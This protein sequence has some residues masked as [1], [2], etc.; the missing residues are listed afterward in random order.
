MRPVAGQWPGGSP[1]LDH[2]IKGVSGG[3][4]GAGEILAAVIDVLGIDE[5]ARSL[6]VTSGALGGLTASEE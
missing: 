5:F 2:L 4:L 6:F 3:A 1:L